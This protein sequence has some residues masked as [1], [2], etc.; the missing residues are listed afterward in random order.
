MS[1]QE[2]MVKE[3]DLPY[4]LLLMCTG[5]L[6]FPIAK[7]YDIEIWLPSQEKYRETHS[8]S[9]TSDFQARRLNIKYRSNKET[10]F[11]YT[12]NA[13][14]FA[15][16]RTLIAILEN[17]QQKDGSILIPKALQKYAGFT[18]IPAK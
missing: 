5:E 2:K 3:L 15:I 16:G 1:L 4:R 11:L 7:K 18:K 14:A 8:A 10:G 9:T 12:L 17:Y 6:G 13:T